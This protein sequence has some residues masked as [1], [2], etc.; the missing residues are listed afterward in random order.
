MLVAWLV[1]LVLSVV[2]Y[3]FEWQQLDV[4]Q[5]SKNIA[6]QQQAHQQSQLASLQSNFSKRG[7]VTVLGKTL[8]EMNNRR[9]KL[10]LY[11]N[12]WEC[13]PGNGAGVA[14]IMS[15]L[16]EL[17]MK[18]LWLTE[19]SVFQGQLNLVGQTRNPERVPQLIDK[20]QQLALSDRRFARLHLLSDEQNN[21]HEFSLQSVD[22]VAPQTPRGGN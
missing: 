20:L 5:E 8:E 13:V 14:G 19:I 18:A 9:D 16:T 10:V 12:S 11:Y 3:V 21:L 17:D 22:F 6:V 2:L 15:G 1:G 7:D 4:V